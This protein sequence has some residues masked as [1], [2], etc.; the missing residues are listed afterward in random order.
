MSYRQKRKIKHEKL[1]A[2]KTLINNGAVKSSKS[3]HLVIPTK[4]SRENHDPEH[5]G[6]KGS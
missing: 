2:L 5:K 6:A 1:E 4:E 3:Y